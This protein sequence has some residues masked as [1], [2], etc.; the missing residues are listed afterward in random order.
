M[1]PR[2]VRLIRGLIANEVIFLILAAFSR[3]K[4]MGFSRNNG[5]WNPNYF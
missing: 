4:K 1:T 5:G 3:P 2:D